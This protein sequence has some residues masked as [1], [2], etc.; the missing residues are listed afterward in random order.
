M[1]TL[2][3]MYCIHSKVAINHLIQICLKVVCGMGKSN[4]ADMV[5]ALLDFEG[6][7]LKSTGLVQLRLLERQH[8]SEIPFTK[9]K[10]TLR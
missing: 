7:T 2:L 9:N 10:D 1:V 6:L 3:A 5:N 8:H 4:L